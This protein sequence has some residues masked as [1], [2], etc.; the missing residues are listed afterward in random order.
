[1]LAAKRKAETDLGLRSGL[2]SKYVRTGTSVTVSCDDYNI[3][4]CRY[5]K[6]H[7]SDIGQPIIDGL[8]FQVHR[9]ERIDGDYWFLDMLGNLWQNSIIRYTNV[10]QFNCN[11]VLMLNCTARSM[12]ANILAPFKVR[13]LV[14]DLLIG[15]DSCLYDRKGQF[16]VD[17]V[18]TAHTDGTDII[19]VHHDGKLQHISDRTSPLVRDILKLRE[20]RKAVTA[21]GSILA[22]TR[23]GQLFGSGSNE[24]FQC[25]SDVSGIS[26]PYAF[27]FPYHVIDFNFHKGVGWALLEDQS[28]WV[29]GDNETVLRFLQWHD[30][31]FISPR[32]LVI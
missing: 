31:F 10:I 3:Y 26:Y 16:I 12:K 23:D 5:G 24:S 4:V 1:M 20:V 11:W 6:V 21:D 30:Q 2:Q 13:E 32:P 17:N 19:V 27:P 25:G 28:I 9:M 29:W 15:Q 7:S 8:P 22:L 14:G 18:Q